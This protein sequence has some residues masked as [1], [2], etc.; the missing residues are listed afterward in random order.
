MV[1]ILNLQDCMPVRGHHFLCL[2]GYK[3]NAYSPSHTETSWDR[4]SLLLKRNPDK[5][6][7]VVTEKD[8]LC[9]GCPNDG[10]KGPAC[11][12]NFLRELDEKVRKFLELEPNKPYAY[13]DIIGKTYV[14]N[15]SEKA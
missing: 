1:R 8:A 3:G 5:K 10:I 7:V 11:N 12:K 15:D 9:V 6:V 13:S 2:P 14:F 4:I